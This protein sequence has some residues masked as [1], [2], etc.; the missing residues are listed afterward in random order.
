MSQE[1]MLKNRFRSSSS[2]VTSVQGQ[3][4]QYVLLSFTG[5]NSWRLIWWK[6]GFKTK[7]RTF[8]QTPEFNRTGKSRDRN[9]M[10][11]LQPEQQRTAVALSSR[12]HTGTA[13]VTRITYEGVADT[14]PSCILIQDDMHSYKHNAHSLL[15]AMES[16]GRTYCASYLYVHEQAGTH[17]WI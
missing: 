8:T 7:K 17:T 10:H 6:G 14:S 3:F 1:H 9:V 16:E 13:A 12:S 4:F 11:P 15:R 5:E 2:T